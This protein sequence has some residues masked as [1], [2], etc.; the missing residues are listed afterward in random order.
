MTLPPSRQLTLLLVDP[1]AADRAATRWL[2]DEAAPDAYAWIEADGSAAALAVIAERAPACVLTEQRLADGDGLTLLRRLRAERAHPPVPMVLLTRSGNEQL[3]V[4][5]FRAGAEDYLSKERLTG[6]DLLRAVTAATERHARRVEATQRQA[7]MEETLQR[8]STLIERSFEAVIIWELGG[9][10]VAW[11]PAAERLYGYTAA[12]AIG[13]RSHE[14]LQTVHPLPIA[15]FEARLRDERLWTGAL[16]H[17]TRDGRN[18]MIESR[19]IV[20]ADP[21]G[22]LLVLETSRDVTARE[23]AEEALRASEARFR[24]LAE[25]M[26][27]LLWVVGQDGALQ[28]INTPWYSYTG[29]KEGE[30][31]GFGWL[32]AV[33][34]DDLVRLRREWRDAIAT[35]GPFAFDIRYRRADG[36]YRWFACSSVPVTDAAGAVAFNVGIALDVDD[37]RRVEQERERLIAFASHDL[38]NPLAAISGFTE[39]LQRAL[40][41]GRAPSAEQLTTSLA[42]IGESA[43]RMNALIQ[44]LLDTTRLQAGRPL[45]L[46]PE[47]VDLA[48][49]TCERVEAARSTSEKHQFVLDLPSAPLIGEWDR[50]RLER[51]LDN[52]LSNA[53]KYSPDGGAITLRLVET[54][55]EGRWATLTVSDGG[56]GI[57]AADLPLLFQQFR[58]GGNVGA[59]PGNGLGLA[60]IQ[61]IIHQHG[62]DI[63]LASA[64]GHGTTVTVR[65]PLP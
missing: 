5:A 62:G 27:G 13:R 64:E 42:G 61:Q 23:Q 40:D 48:T 15:A 1:S 54:A 41:R 44:E 4:E 34:P 35:G 10:I 60:S 33:H 55:E 50:A 31:L 43:A 63:T 53:I 56:L 21:Q 20:I 19:H 49:L 26:P 12:E 65:L 52:L 30:A 9:G 7:Q 37:R 11:N 22:R 14:L 29:Q 18:V 38:R 46:Q 32:G 58:R 3:A 16:T 36:V 39:L 17:R 24:S 59:L 51:V 8:Q 25:A 6:P 45:D 2:L 47:A 28:Y 57:P